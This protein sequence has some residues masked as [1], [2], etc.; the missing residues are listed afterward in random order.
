MHFINANINYATTNWRYKMSKKKTL[1]KQFK[2]DVRNKQIAIDY[3]EGG[4][5]TKEI[6]DKY[7]TSLATVYYILHSF[8]IS[9]EKYKPTTLSYKSIAEDYAN[10]LEV[11]EVADKYNIS[12]ATVYRAMRS[13]NTPIRPAPP[14]PIQQ[15]IIDKLVAGQRQVDI[16]K[17]MNV[18]RQYINDINT[19]FVKGKYEQH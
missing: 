15:E 5:P 2:K 3:L 12:V 11:Q 17:E 6:A 7:N 13:T 8:D 4:M 18:S 16:A 14:T 19:R 1:L 10:G 9:I